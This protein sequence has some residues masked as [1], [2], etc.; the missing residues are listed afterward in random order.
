M[1]KPHFSGGAIVALAI[2]VTAAPATAAPPRAQTGSATSVTQSTAT[3][4]AT[5]NPRGLATTYRFEYGRLKDTLGQQTPRTSLT[6]GN[7]TIRVSADIT[8]LT[9]GTTFYYR[10][11]AENKDGSSPGGRRSFTTA[12]AATGATLSGPSIVTYGRQATLHGAATGPGN[13]GARAV[14]Q[15][16]S[17]PFTNPFAPL[18]SP[19]QTG[20]DGAY[21]FNTPPLLSTTRFRVVVETKPAATSPVVEVPVRVAVGM[22]LSDTTPRRHQRVRFSGSV[23]P[24]HPGAPV[25]IQKRS[26]SGRYVT[27][28]RTSLGPSDGVRSRYARR[29]RVPRS[30]RYRV[31]ALIR[32]GDHVSGASP[33]RYVRTH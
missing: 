17:F 23:R 9:A 24:P 5:V 4:H 33:S 13:R 21:V 3:L 11:V 8:G 32:D 26:A 14:L 20:G 6:A 16:A 15:Y 2:L 29:I 30:G 7:A 12:K 28:A 31:R 18:G 22:T 1:P 25:S 10:V 19:I 27:V